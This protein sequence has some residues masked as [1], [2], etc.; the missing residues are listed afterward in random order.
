[1]KYGGMVEM[2][3][4]MNPKCS[5]REVKAVEKKSLKDYKL[6]VSIISIFALIFVLSINCIALS[7]SCSIMVL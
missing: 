3:I 5:E 6:Y 7:Y 2:I 1:M 4:V